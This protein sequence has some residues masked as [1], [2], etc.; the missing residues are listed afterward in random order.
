MLHTRSA[1]R[2][3]LPLEEARRG[4]CARVIDQCDHVVLCPSVYR[5]RPVMGR[6]WCPGSVH[7]VLNLVP[8]VQVYIAIHQEDETPAD[9]SAVDFLMTKSSGTIDGAED[10]SM[11]GSACAA[12][13]FSTAAISQVRQGGLIG[14]DSPCESLEKRCRHR[15]MEHY[16]ASGLP[17]PR[18]V[19]G[20]RLRR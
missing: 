12:Y 20:L 4:S 2:P 16:L 1:G 9:Y 19:M 3:S 6:A 7:A 10:S 14:D 11:W 5:S 15:R 8:T 13:S 17:D 18:E